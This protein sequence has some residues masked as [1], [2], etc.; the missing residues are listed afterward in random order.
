MV[1]K[2]FC[3]NW[4]GRDEAQ[5]NHASEV[6]YMSSRNARRGARRKTSR[7]TTSCLK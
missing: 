6:T 4:P 2:I 1:S 7:K 3:K 5:G